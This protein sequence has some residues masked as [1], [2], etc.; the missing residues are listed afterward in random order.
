MRF[1]GDDLILDTNDPR[2]VEVLAIGL[3]RCATSSL[4]TALASKWLGYGPCMHMAHVAPWPERSQMVLDALYEPDRE[5]RLK[6][7]HK[8]FAGFHSQ[9]DLPGVAFTDDL[10]DMFPDAKL[11][12]NQRQDAHAFAKSMMG[13]IM[14]FSTW[15][16]ILST[17]LLRTDRL[18]WRMHFGIY[19]VKY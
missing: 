6:I 10:M 14:F 3:P 12:L 15:P 4:Q 8:L 11:I 5:T 1:L 9:T 2:G 17:F 19:R 16:Y 13:A 18:H 7:L